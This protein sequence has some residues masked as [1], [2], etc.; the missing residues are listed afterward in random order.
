MDKPGKDS[1]RHREAG[2]EEV[3]VASG[4]RW[5]LLHE[6]D[7]PALPDLLARLTPVDLVLIEGFK[8]SPQ[9]KIEVYR[10]VLGK[11][12]LWP[13]RP[14]VVAV[15]TDAPLPDCDRTILPLNDP[16]IVAAWIL[17]FMQ[18]GHGARTEA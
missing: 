17:N 15:A 14:D 1:F 7:E 5:V 12:P 3:L 4:T 10:P 18:H 6:G 8:G 2:A 9:P 16:S 13:G 11:P